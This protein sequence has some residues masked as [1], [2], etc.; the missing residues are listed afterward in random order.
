MIAS[1]M[2]HLAFIHLHAAAIPVGLDLDIVVLLGACIALA[3]IA[4]LFDDC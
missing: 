4:A 2:D 1:H 3:V